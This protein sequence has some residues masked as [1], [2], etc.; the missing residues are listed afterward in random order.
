MLKV[1]KAMTL[2]ALDLFAE[3]ELLAA[4]KDEH[5]HWTERYEGQA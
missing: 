5:A 4:A 1:A 3:P 2:T